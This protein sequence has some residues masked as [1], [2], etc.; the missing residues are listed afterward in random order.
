[1]AR[2]Q[3]QVEIFGDSCSGEVN[4]DRTRLVKAVE[5]LWDSRP[6]DWLQGPEFDAALRTLTEHLERLERRVHTEDWN[7]RQAVARAEAA[8][9]RVR[10]LEEALRATVDDLI[11]MRLEP[12]LEA[13]GSPVVGYRWMLAIDFDPDWQQFSLTNEGAACCFRLLLADEM[14]EALCA[15]VTKP[16]SEE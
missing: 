7:W 11:W 5:T 2:R 13:D 12:Q 4:A 14:V 16:S 3:I 10:E 9:A 1:M 15:A 8:E 6:E